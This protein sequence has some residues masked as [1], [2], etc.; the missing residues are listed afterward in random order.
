MQDLQRR[1]EFV[2]E[3]SLSAADAGQ[4]RGRAQHRPVAAER[5][6]VR[7]DAPD[8]G[9][10]VAVD[11][12]LLLDLVEHRLVLGE[13]VAA[14]RDARIVYQDV[15]IV[16]E[17]LGE[18]RLLVDQVHDAQVGRQAARKLVEARARDVALG[19]LRPQTFNAGFESGGGRTDGARLHIRM[20]GRAG[21]AAPFFRRGRGGSR[22]W[23]LRRHDRRFDRAADRLRG[24]QPIGLR[25]ARRGCAEQQ[26]AAQHQPGKR[27]GMLRH[28]PVFRPHEDRVPT[29]HV[30]CLV[31]MSN[32]RPL[33]GQDMVERG[34]TA[35]FTDAWLGRFRC[36]SR[37]RPA[38]SR[39]I[40]SAV[41]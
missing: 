24:K 34:L 4:R 10:D 35:Q 14:V 41:G 27:D 8:R 2:A 29:R 15:E 20:A 26:H 31:A 12:V 23:R 9:D 39:S 18:L 16:P 40:S 38:R 33:L 25:K 30:V 28:L 5:A 36:Q 32:V 13:D 1:E 11:A 21:F 19:G 22:R 17:R 37:Y 3:I 7:L 6:V